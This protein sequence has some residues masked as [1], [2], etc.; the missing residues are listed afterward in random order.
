M[1]LLEDVS[2]WHGEGLSGDG[3]HLAEGGAKGPVSLSL[4]LVL[5]GVEITGELD[6]VVGDVALDEIGKGSSVL[7]D[8][9]PG[10]ELGDV[11]ADV[12]AVSE[13]VG[14]ASDDLTELFKASGPLLVEE[15]LEALDGKLS[16]GLAIADAGSDLS[17][18]LLLKN[19]VHDTSKH[20]VV[21]VG[22]QIADWLSKHLLGGGGL[23]G[24]GNHLTD[25]LAEGPVGLGLPLVLGGVEVTGELDKVV[26]HVALDKIGKSGCV[27]EDGGPRLKGSNIISEMGAILESMGKS[28]GYLAELLDT[29]EP[30]AME[31]VLEALVGKLGLGRAVRDAS[32]DLS[33]ALSINET[34]NK[35][36]K[37]LVVFSSRQLTNRLGIEH[38][39][40]INK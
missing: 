25:G 5:G 38:L 6:K 31:K 19:A 4:P 21:L 37:H 28:L 12:L 15:V 32:L 1:P 3:E 10:L 14:K 8:S 2:E 16:L 20:S 39:V 24:D 22:G 11:V 30:L 33:E 27:L 29:I 18:A 13:D 40:R 26:S 34:I 35:T 23:S 9:S 36:E 7:E 17:E